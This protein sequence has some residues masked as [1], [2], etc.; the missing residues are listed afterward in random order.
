MKTISI[1]L[2]ALC[3]AA[4]VVFGSYYSYRRSIRSE[5]LQAYGAV[6]TVGDYQ[7]NSAF[8][9]ADLFAR[10]KLIALKSKN[11]NPQDRKV[12][13]CIEAYLGAIESLNSSLSI[14]DTRLREPIAVQAAQQAQACVKGLH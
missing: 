3:V 8:L 11:L 9:E 12:V 14:E 1:A 2:T 7:G 13:E 5:I 10:E 6:Q 4:L